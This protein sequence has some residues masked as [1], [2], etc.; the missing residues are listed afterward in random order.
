MSNICLYCIQRKELHFGALD[1]INV[2]PCNILSR[3]N[4]NNLTT[5][6]RLMQYRR[7]FK[8]VSFF[9]TFSPLLNGYEE[10]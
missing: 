5:N 9:C 6:F 7:R 3:N 1:E 8:F 10:R 4:V 2:L